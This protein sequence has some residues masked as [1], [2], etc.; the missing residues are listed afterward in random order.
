MGT[1]PKYKPIIYLSVH[2]THL[3]ELGYELRQLKDL[4]KSLK[5]K[6]E[7]SHGNK[8]NNI[9]FSEYILKNKNNF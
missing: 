8:I 7:D 6:I 9:K 3:K 2:P 4:I 1:L 5:Y